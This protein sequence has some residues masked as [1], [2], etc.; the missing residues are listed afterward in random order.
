MGALEGLPCDCDFAVGYRDCRW[1]KV[2]W[3]THTHTRTVAV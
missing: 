1:E 3:D 2:A